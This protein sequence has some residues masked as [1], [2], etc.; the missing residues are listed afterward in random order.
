MTTTVIVTRDSFDPSASHAI[1]CEVNGATVQSGDTSDMIFTC[2][3]ALSEASRYFP[4]SPGDLIF[5]G[6]P[7]GVMI[8]RKKEDRTWLKP[9]D[10]VNVTIDG[11]G[12]LTTPLV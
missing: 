8:G 3:K 2:Q 4:L 6:T 7:A 1:R 10:T 11:I 12:T 5:T 9:G